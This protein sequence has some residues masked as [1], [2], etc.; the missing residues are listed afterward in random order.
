MS[1]TPSVETND[2]P[3]NAGAAAAATAEKPA[4]PA[5]P[6]FN[7][8]TL[9]NCTARMTHKAWHLFYVNRKDMTFIRETP[10]RAT[11][12]ARTAPGAQ[13]LHTLLADAGVTS[14]SRND[15]LLAFT[16]TFEQIQTVIK[17]SQAFM[18]DAVKI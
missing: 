1:D 7:V 14:I 15:K 6:P 2:A 8:D 4:P 10:V 9:L 16:A 11:L 13:E 12:E 5:E 18:L 17:Q 3:A